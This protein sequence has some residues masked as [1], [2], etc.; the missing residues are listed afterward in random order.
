[1]AEGSGKGDPYTA[2]LQPHFLLQL[3]AQGCFGLLVCVNEAAGNT[4]AAARSKDMF[5]QQNVALFVYY[6]GAGAND[7]SR[8]TKASQ[9]QTNSRAS[10]GTTAP[11]VFEH[12]EELNTAVGGEQ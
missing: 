3:T 4:P 10:D 12:V 8:M 11:E 1:M 2:K 7:E 5:Q 9:E 6:D